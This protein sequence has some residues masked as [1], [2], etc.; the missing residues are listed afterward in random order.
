MLYRFLVCPENAPEAKPCV[1]NPP[2]IVEVIS[3]SIFLRDTEIKGFGD[4][5]SLGGDKGRM[6]IR[7]LVPP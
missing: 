2:E 5:D 7:N 4:A 6:G 3:G 1:V